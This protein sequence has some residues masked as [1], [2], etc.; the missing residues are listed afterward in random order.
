MLPC[1]GFSF[2]ECCAAF[3]VKWP[4]V[5]GDSDGRARAAAVKDPLLFQPWII[6]YTN[7]SGELV[8]V[9]LAFPRYDEG[10]ER[11][12]CTPR[13]TR[14]K[15]IIQPETVVSHPGGPALHTWTLHGTRN[16]FLTGSN[17]REPCS[18]G[19]RDPEAD[20]GGRMDREN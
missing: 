13:R 4:T 19:G 1:C 16:D 8:H 9:A 5:A 18:Q 7:D 10:A 2:V 15:Y 17:Q 11:F 14:Q 3:R 6:L 12:R 20:R